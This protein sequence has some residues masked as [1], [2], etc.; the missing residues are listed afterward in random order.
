MRRVPSRQLLT[1]DAHG[2]RHGLRTSRHRRGLAKK[3]QEIIRRQ[4]EFWSACTGRSR[5]DQGVAQDSRTRP[6]AGQTA[7]A[8][9]PYSL[10]GAAPARSVGRS[11]TAAAGLRRKN[12]AEDHRDRASTA[13]PVTPL[14][15][16]SRRPVRRS[17]DRRPARGGGRRSGYAGRQF[18]PQARDGR[19]PRHRG[20]RCIGGR[21]DGPL[22]HG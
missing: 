22:R 4:C 8:C 6:K 18:P 19:R 14:Q 17:V 21:G 11:D 13:Q 2:A 1:S 5:R 3:I 7:L 16:R 9:A 20:D 12:R 15:A 10:S